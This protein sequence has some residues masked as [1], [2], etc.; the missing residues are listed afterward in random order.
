VSVEPGPSECDVSWA[1]ALAG[2]GGGACDISR[3]QCPRGGK[4]DILKIKIDFCDVTN[5]ILLSQ[6]K[7]N[8][9]YDYDFFKGRNLY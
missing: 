7:G 2:R 3:R 4:M 1:I 5:C 9:I 8:A 6:T